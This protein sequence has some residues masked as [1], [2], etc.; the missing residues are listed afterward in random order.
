MNEPLK[1]KCGAEARVRY[2]MP[3]TWV[4]CKKKCGMKTGYYCDAYEQSKR[5]AIDDWNRLVKKNG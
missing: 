5:Q 2:R 4:E 3:F 1:C